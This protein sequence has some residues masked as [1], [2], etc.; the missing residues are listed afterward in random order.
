MDYGV[1]PRPN[2]S[3]LVCSAEQSYETASTGEQHTT[4]TLPARSKRLASSG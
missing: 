2:P 3:I 1:L 4:L